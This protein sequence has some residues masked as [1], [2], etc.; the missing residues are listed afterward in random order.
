MKQKRGA[1]VEP[2]GLFLIFPASF[3]ILNF[4]FLILKHEC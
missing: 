2:Q 1:R 3:L 4:S